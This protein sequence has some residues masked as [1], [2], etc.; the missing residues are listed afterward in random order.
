MPRHESEI[1]YLPSGGLLAVSYQ[2]S[3]NGNSYTIKLTWERGRPA[4]APGYSKMG[5]LLKTRSQVTC[6]DAIALKI[7]KV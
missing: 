5:K 3:G 4:R 7:L 2:L 1:N 6:P